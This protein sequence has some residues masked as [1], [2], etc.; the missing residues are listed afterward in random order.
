MNVTI[1]RTVR[2]LMAWYV[3]KRIASTRYIKKNAIFLV[4]KSETQA[5]KMRP[6]PLPIPMMP[7][8]PA[9]V[10]ALALPISWN[11]G[12]ACET[13]DKP[14]VVL[15]DISK[16]RAHHCQVASAWPRVKSRSDRCDNCAAVG[17]QPSG[18]HPS[19]GF[20][21]KAPAAIATIPYAIPR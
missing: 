4:V 16:Q 14:A 9:A 11:I 13:T 15:I 21:M 2:E 5:Q 19:G 8:R 20:C 7:T 1:A 6:A 17:V 10:T 12:A 18:L 3:Q